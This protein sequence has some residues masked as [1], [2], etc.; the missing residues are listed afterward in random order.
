MQRSG[1]LSLLPVHWWTSIS[2][3]SHI[4][5]LYCSYL[6]ICSFQ[7]DS[8]PNCVTLISLAKRRLLCCWKNKC[9][10]F[11]GNMNPAGE[12]GAINCTWASSEQQCNVSRISIVT[13]QPLKTWGGLPRA[14]SGTCEHKT[15][16]SIVHASVKWV[17]WPDLTFSWP[18][19]E[20]KLLQSKKVLAKGSIVHKLN[21]STNSAA[22]L[23]VWEG[24]ITVPCFP[25]CFCLE[26]KN[27]SLKIET[28][29]A[30]YGVG[31]HEIFNW[32]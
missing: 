23:W 1:Y 19:L 15:W 13:L 4:F 30:L 12:K 27:I 11:H 3:G 22:I 25:Q 16:V 8:I 32:S 20:T 14:P 2:W 31:H 26:G 28:I 24:T 18:C 29:I 17:V 5:W 9:T 10:G 6:N 7:E 21:I